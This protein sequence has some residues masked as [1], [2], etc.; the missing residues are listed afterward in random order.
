MRSRHLKNPS[1]MTRSRPPKPDPHILLPGRKPE[2]FVLT[3]AGNIV[4]HLGVQMYAGRPVPAIAELISN[5][6]D[7]DAKQ[8]EVRLPLDKEWRPR[9]VKQFIEV[10]D[11]GN[12]MTWD[13]IRD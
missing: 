10:S 3:F 5:A 8:V 12:G 9:N 7:A 1:S 2:E 11:N 13:M 4:K 6:W